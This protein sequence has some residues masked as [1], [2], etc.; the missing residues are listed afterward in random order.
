MFAYPALV[1]YPPGV[2]VRHGGEHLPLPHAAARHAVRL[3]VC[4]ASIWSHRSICSASC[5]SRSASISSPGPPV[6]RETGDAP[7]TASTLHPDRR[8]DR[9]DRDRRLPLPHRSD[10]RRARRL[11][12][13]ARDAGRRPARRRSAAGAMSAPVDAVLLSHDQHAD[14]LD[15]AGRHFLPKAPRVLDDRDRREQSASAAMPQG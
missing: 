7:M 15:H 3:A 2:S 9:A 10:L 8:P 11:S 14:N 13:A 12:T 5:R 1:P 6:R 4:S